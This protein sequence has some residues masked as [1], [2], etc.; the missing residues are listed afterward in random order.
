M[1]IWDMFFSY[2]VLIIFGIFA[3]ALGYHS[4]QWNKDRD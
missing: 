2:G 3:A 4:W 1:T